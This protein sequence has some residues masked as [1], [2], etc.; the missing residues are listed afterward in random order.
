MFKGQCCGGV[1]CNVHF[2]ALVCNKYS[3]LSM[4]Y[5][6]GTIMHA[7]NHIKYYISFL[8]LSHACHTHLYKWAQNVVICQQSEIFFKIFIIF[9]LQSKGSKTLKGTRQQESTF[10]VLL[11]LV[12][13]IYMVSEGSKVNLQLYYTFN[14]VFSRNF[15]LFKVH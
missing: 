1:T 8:G 13:I 14:S 11:P 15:V 7:H 10:L 6:L 2:V 12:V 4:Q 5:D 3:R 9:F